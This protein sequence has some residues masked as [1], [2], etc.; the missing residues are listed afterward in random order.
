MK[1]AECPKREAILGIDPGSLITG[2]GVIEAEGNRLRYVAHGAIGTS[3]ALGQAERLKQIYR[4][5]GDVIRCYGPAAVSLEKVFLS[6]NVQSAL[7]LG[8]ARGVA[9]LAA[10]EGQV[11]LSEYSATEIKVAVV[12]Y[13]HATKEQIQRMVTTLLGVRGALRTDAADALA[14]AICHFHR[15]THQARLG[16]SAI[17]RPAKASW[18]QYVATESKR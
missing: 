6:R 18:R 9:M 3:T 7:K 5:I 11:P 2:W 14:A 10:S 16:E 13:G 12:G 1:T 15:R 4:G 17:L 8:Q